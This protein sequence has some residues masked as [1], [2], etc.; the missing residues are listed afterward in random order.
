MKLLTLFASLLISTS[1]ATFGA[2][3]P[4]SDCITKD[5]QT[6]TML[7][8]LQSESQAVAE[9]NTSP[10]LTAMVLAKLNCEATA[11]SENSDMLDRLQ[12][13]TEDISILKP[14]LFVAEV[15]EKQLE[16]HSSNS[17]AFSKK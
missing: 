11:S 16:K 13:E 9:Q 5:C 14:V 4:T 6:V 12:K 8:H 7:E 2:E 17:N 3:A 15:I 1:S 10:Q